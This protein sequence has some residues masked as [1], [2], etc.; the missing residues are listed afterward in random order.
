MMKKEGEGDYCTNGASPEPVDGPNA[1]PVGPSA[2]YW[3]SVPTAVL[4]IV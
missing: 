3:K 2:S 4:P 1:V